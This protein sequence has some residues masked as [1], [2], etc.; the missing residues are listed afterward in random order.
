M[1]TGFLQIII[2]LSSS[3]EEEVTDPGLEYVDLNTPAIIFSNN[4]R[5]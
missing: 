2:L 5:L 4:P 3:I 1:A